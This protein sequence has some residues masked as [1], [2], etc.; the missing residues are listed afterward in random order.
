[1]PRWL[2]AGC[3][4]AVQ[5]HDAGKSASAITRAGAGPTVVTCARSVLV[6][7]H[8]AGWVLSIRKDLSGRLGESSRDT[9]FDQRFETL[10]RRMTNRLRCGRA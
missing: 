3:G 6:P 5:R 4:D 1:M 10:R 7:L 2:V 9:A 8:V